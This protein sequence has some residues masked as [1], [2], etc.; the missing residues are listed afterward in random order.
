F[1][2]HLTYGKMAFLHYF[3][4]DIQLLD[5]LQDVK[6]GLKNNHRTIFTQTIVD[7]HLLDEPTVKL[8]QYFYHDRAVY[9]KF[10]NDDTKQQTNSAD[11]TIHDDSKLTFGQYAQVSM[12]PGVITLIFEAALK[13]KQYYS[14][15]FYYDINHLSP[16]S[17]RQLKHAHIERQMWYFIRHQWFV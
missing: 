10:N 16:T 2:R 15:K 17:F 3:G 12:T 14:K 5:N 8:I 13:L 1:D 9:P 7:G 6:E 11:A 4:F